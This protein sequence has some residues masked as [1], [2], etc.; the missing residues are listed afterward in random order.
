MKGDKQ[1]TL[2]APKLNFPGSN[3]DVITFEVE[4][5]PQTQYLNLPPI[6]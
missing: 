3:L 6:L 5:F 1:G 2:T 4:V